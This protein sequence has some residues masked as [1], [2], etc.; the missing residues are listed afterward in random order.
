[1]GGGGLGDLEGNLVEAKHRRLV[2]SHRTG[3]GARDLKPGPE[4]R[5]LLNVRIGGA[6]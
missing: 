6:P 4:V 1:M 5:D 2:R 3:A